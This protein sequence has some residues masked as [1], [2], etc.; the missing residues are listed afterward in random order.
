[1][2]RWACCRAAASPTGMTGRFWS[3]DELELSAGFAL[4][5]EIAVD[6]PAT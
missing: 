4:S 5:D 6:I 3:G 2:R 1:M